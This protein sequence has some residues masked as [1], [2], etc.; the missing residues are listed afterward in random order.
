ME[1]MEKREAWIKGR[2]VGPNFALSRRR[3]VRCRSE[4]RPA[5]ST[6]S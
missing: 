5:S 3:V 1:V 4:A 6:P 2:L